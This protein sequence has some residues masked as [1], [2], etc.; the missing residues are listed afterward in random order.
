[1]ATVVIKRQTVSPIE[2]VVVRLSEEEARRLR[3]A[4]KD[5]TSGPML[6][7]RDLLSQHLGE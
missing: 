4:L 1:M 5:E 6:A 3:R 7:L 2:E